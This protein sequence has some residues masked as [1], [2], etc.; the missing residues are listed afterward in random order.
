MAFLNLCL[1]S[2]VYLI[3]AG[4]SIL[5]SL[6]HKMKLF[7]IIVN[8]IFVSIWTWFLNY[9]C[10]KGYSVISW[11]LVF[12]PLILFTIMIAGTIEILHKVGLQPIQNNNNNNKSTKSN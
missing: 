10:K 1:P 6:F 8:V 4:I 5:L 11:F 12:L 3:I 2:L 7:T 9:L